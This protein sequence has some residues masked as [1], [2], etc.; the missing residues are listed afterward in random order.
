[1]NIIVCVDENYN[2]GNNNALLFNIKKDMEFF[3]DKTQNNVIIMGRK[4]LQSLPNSKPLKN[5]INIVMTSSESIE[6]CIC[7]NSIDSLFD[8]LKQYQNKDI[9]VIG[10]E[11]V[12]SLLLPYCTKAYITKVFSSKEG[13]TKFP[14]IDLIPNWTLTNSSEVYLQGDVEYIFTMYENKNI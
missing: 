7:V 12:Y 5:R 2:I 13:D 4:T 11:Q 3:K 1:M 9:F 8:V 6:G 14:N 10:G